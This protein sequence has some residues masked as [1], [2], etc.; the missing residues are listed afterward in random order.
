MARDVTHIVFRARW[1]VTPYFWLVMTF[2][3]TVAWAIDDDV[4]EDFIDGQ[5]AFIVKHGWRFD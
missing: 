2:L 4:L 3:W 5:A 1:W